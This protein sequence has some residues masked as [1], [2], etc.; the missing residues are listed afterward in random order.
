MESCITDATLYETAN[1]GKKWLRQN[2]FPF[3]D[4][5]PL[6]KSKYAFENG[7]LF[8]IEIPVVN[9]F[10]ILEK[11][12]YWLDHYGLHCDRF[13]ETKGSFLLSDNEIKKMLSLCSERQIGIT[14][15]LSPRPEYDIKA[16]FYRSNFGMEQC[17]RLNNNDAIAYSIEEALRLADLGC[18]GLVIYDIG[19]LSL[20]YEMRNQGAL[21]V[22]M[23]FKASS[24]CMATNPLI[25]KILHLHGADSITVVHDASLVVLQEMRRLCPALVLDVP[26]DVYSDK[27]GYIRFNDIAD[28]VQVA[29]PVILKLGASAQ[30]NPYDPVNDAIIKARVQRAVV[31]IE[32][33]NRVLNDITFLNVSNR[34]R[35]LPSF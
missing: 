6:I 12:I 14:F 24:H 9:S 26:I 28:I 17:R 1:R 19:V 7:A 34:H 18:R 23:I 3:T 4:H 35:C 31:A 29:A 8:G 13:N 20:L 5:L 16:S 11:T 22:D 2:G 32:H 15:S 21:P 27:G 25:A 30:N 10:E 33:L